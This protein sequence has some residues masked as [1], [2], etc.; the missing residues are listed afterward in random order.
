LTNFESATLLISFVGLAVNVIVFIVFVVQLRLLVRQLKQ[1]SS[2]TALDHD[3]RRQQAT[4]EFIAQTLERRAEMRATL[5][6]DRDGVAVRKM[7]AR[8][9]KGDRETAKIVGEYLSLH[10]LLATGVRMGIF[11]FDVLERVAGRILAMFANYE[12]WIREQRIELDNPRL[13]ED[14]EW[15]VS[16]VHEHRSSARADAG[17]TGDEPGTSRS[18]SRRRTR[19]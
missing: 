9:S 5:P 15:F 13:Y 14:L 19:R 10:E 7:L 18:R 3:R 4:L 8:V 16:R 2:T 6:N 1:A 12:P 17:V 11:D